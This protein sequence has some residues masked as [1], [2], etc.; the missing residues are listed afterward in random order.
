MSG[1]SHTNLGRLNPDG[2][3]D[4]SFTAEADNLVYALAVSTD[5]KIV[6]GGVFDRLGGQS[7]ARIGRLN[8]DASIDPVFFPEVFGDVTSLAVQS[9]GKINV[10]GG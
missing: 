7:R 5:S 1:Q 10:G 9:D 4:A 8:A 6:V 3:L 2:S